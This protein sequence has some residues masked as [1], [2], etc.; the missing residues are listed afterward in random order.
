VVVSQAICA[1]TNGTYHGNSSACGSAGCSPAIGYIENGDAGELPGTAAIVNNGSGALTVIHGSFNRFTDADMYRIRICDPQNFSANMTWSG[2]GEVT[3]FTTGGV[4]IAQRFGY[5]GPAQI[6]NQFVSSLP[7]G[8]YD[9]AVSAFVKMPQDSLAQ[10]L[11]LN[12]HI[13]PPNTFPTYD[14]IERAPDGPGAANPIDHWDQGGGQDGP[15]TVTL[16]GACF[17]SSG[18]PPCYANCDA[19][20]TAPVLNVADFTCFLQKFAAGNAYANCDNS[21][22]APV[23]NV[24]DFTCFLQKFAAGCP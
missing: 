6:T 14:N 17:I 23:L 4:G 13:I 5:N 16:T 22:T 20:T 11:W 21:T 9:L 15:Y 18:P 24:A 19:S 1:A 10:N 12:G 8:E 3:L 7:A 2:L